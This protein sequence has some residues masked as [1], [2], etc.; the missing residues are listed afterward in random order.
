MRLEENTVLNTKTEKFV[1]A[2][3]SANASK[4][5]NG[6][7]S[8]FCQRSSRLQKHSISRDVV[9]HYTPEYKA[10]DYNSGVKHT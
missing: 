9:L 6:T 8:M 2:K 3:I 5:G 1:T 4:Q 7:H 10:A